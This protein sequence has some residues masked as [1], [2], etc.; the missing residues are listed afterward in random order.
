MI[1][2]ATAN[3]LWDLTFT[4]PNLT[5]SQKD[6]RRENI[7]VQVG[8]LVGGSSRTNVGLASALMCVLRMTSVAAG[9]AGWVT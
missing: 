9:A 4:F 8:W 7:Y 3:C 1:Q 2:R 5:L 6:F